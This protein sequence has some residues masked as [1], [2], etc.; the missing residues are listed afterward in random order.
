MVEMQV[1][2]EF[3]HLTCLVLFFVDVLEICIYLVDEKCSLF[4]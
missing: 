4:K 2:K 3:S 1:V